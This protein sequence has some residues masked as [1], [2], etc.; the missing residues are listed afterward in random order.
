MAT[1]AGTKV[2]PEALEETFTRLLAAW[3]AL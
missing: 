1:L 2:M 3:K